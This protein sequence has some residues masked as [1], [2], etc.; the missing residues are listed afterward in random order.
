MVVA[1][2][3]AAGPTYNRVTG[4]CAGAS[5]VGTA[6][7]YRAHVF[8][9]TGAARDFDFGLAPSATSGIADP[10]VTVYAGTGSVSSLT[11][12][13]S[14]DDGGGAPASLATASIPAGATITVVASTFD[15]DDVGGYALTITPR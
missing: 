1:G 8:C 14:D 10:F 15:N 4:D 9:N 5:S 11:C 2:T 3:L 6:V 12:M 13:T 7:F